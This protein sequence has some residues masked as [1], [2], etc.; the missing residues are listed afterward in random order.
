MAVYVLVHGGWH[1]AWCW[2]RVK[3]L[4]LEAGHQVYTPTLT[5]LGESANLLTPDVG[6]DTHVQDVV[7]LLQKEDLHQV[8]LVGHSYSGMVITGAADSVPERIRRLVYLEAFVP[9]DGDSIAS[10]A[11]FVVNMLRRDANKHG[12]GWRVNPPRAMPAF[13][14]G[15][16]GITREPDL[17]MVR[18]KVT[19]Q[20]LKTFEQPLH[21][22]HR[23]A[24]ASIDRTYVQCTGSGPI[25]SFVRRVM[26]RGRLPLDEP[27][28]HV[29]QLPAGH[30]AMIIAPRAVADLLL[31]LA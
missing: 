13:L 3:P 14:G 16:Y 29:R 9:R 20:S 27:G 23:E 26:G 21:M 2:D 15:L 11:P 6:L 17:S 8:I 7:G 19:P 12:D 28:W 4:L 31:E 10:V 24:L 1:G 5:G 25:I 22:T 18:S 30:D